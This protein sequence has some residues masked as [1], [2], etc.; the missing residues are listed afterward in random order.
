MNRWLSMFLGIFLL[1]LIGTTAIH[2]PARVSAEQIATSTP[3]PVLLPSAI[4][5]SY[6]PG[7]YNILPTATPTPTHT[8]T[9]EP[10]TATP[11]ETP[12]P[13]DTPTAIP[14][15]TPTPTLT[16]T[17]TPSPTPT[18][19][20]GVIV[21]SSNI[22]RPWEFSS[23]RYLIGEL[24]NN[25]ATNVRFTRVSATLRD[26]SGNVV[27]SDYSF[28][29][30]DTLTPGMRSP[31]LIIFSDPPTWNSYELAV[32]WATTTDTP[33]HLE[34]LNTQSYFDT[35]DAYTVVGEI[36]NQYSEPRTF[37]EAFVT[38]YD[39]EGKVIGVASNYTNPYDLQPGQTASFKA[40]AYFW[41]FKPDR[42]KVASHA[43]IVIDD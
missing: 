1:A 2:Y 8:P 23:N 10:P 30:I 28:S 21:L 5:S 39:A 19:V 43:L 32:T 6:L 18:L 25:T 13:T 34:I 42:T 12:L 26:G 40:E 3:I 35:S 38:M 31:F 20:P 15:D 29:M 4:H 11:T 16:P 37:V 27:D 7:I 17:E 41:M 33:H 24:F 9:I 14:T 36:R 22:Y